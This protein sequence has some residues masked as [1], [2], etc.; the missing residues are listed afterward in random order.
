MARQICPEVFDD[1]DEKTLRRTLLCLQGERHF[2]ESETLDH[3]PLTD[4]ENFGTPV[5]KDSS[6]MRRKRRMSNRSQKSESEE[7][8]EE[9]EDSDSDSNK[10]HRKE[11]PEDAVGKIVI[12]EMNEK[13]KN[14]FFPALVVDPSC[15]K[16]VQTNRKDYIVARSFKDNKFYTVSRSSRKPFLSKDHTYK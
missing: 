7:E 12:V 15:T 13:R 5:M 1:G 3:L 11:E 16:D 8:E 9:E 6:K 2:H 4:P 10:R 14:S